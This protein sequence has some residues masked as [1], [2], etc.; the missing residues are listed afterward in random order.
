VNDLQ[1]SAAKAEARLRDAIEVLPQGIVFLDREGRYILWNERYA[2]IY[3]RSADLLKPGAR[4]ADTLRVGVAR[5][6]YPDAEGREQEWLAERLAMLDQPDR[7]HEQRLSNGRCILI[8]ERK[9]H[10]GGTIGL[11]VDITEIKEREESFRLLFESNPVPLLV[12]DPSTHCL[13]SANEAACAHFG[14][15]R[16]QIEGLPASALFADDEWPEA[17]DLLASNG[18]DKNRFWRQRTRR[19][20]NLE[21]L[22][23]T[24]RSR[25]AG[26]DSTI[27]SVFDVTE[28]RQAEVRMAYMARHDELTGLANR[29]HCREHLHAAL[30]A[31]QPSAVTVAL[32]DLDHFKAVNDT[33][34]HL[35][36]DALLAEASRR[37]Q[38]QIPKRALLCRMGG[39]EFA[40][41]F[42]RASAEQVELVAKSIISALSQPFFLGDCVLHI[43]ATI[44]S[45]R[46]PA[47]ARE[48]STLLRYADLA[49]YEGKGAQRGSYRMFE[50]E[51]DVAAQKKSRLEHDFREAVNRGQ[52]LVHYQPLVDLES[53]ELQ[54]YEALLRWH[55]PEL[56]D[57]GPETFI[58]L[59]EDLGLIDQIGQFVLRSACKEATQW[60]E[61]VSV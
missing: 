58:P 31:S 25:I 21:S 59:A 38:A 32:I 33:Y 12:Y 57:I 9:T 35:V 54:A 44:G 37:M 4:L 29:A 52:L 46:A 30:S 47:D 22:L 53:G 36:G 39:D 16:E 13:R 24:R 2:E 43:G 34:G 8:E 23:F 42:N 26:E 18:S 28:R 27:V 3:Q 51:M 60:D 17:Q 5:G 55:H 48:A 19:G 11:R 15:A 40:V 14:Y 50:L 61:G 45:A 49:L 10:D 7:S 1:A 6:D 20:G 56:G 41:V